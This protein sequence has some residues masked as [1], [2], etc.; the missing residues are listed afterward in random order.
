M[1]KIRSRKNNIATISED[2]HKEEVLN[3][4][5]KQNKTHKI[6]G[7]K[8]SLASSRTFPQSSLPGSYKL[9]SSEGY[10][11][12]L[13]AVGCGPLSLNM[14]MRSASFIEIQ[15]VIMSG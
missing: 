9:V 6:L 14:V 5:G 15:R 12:Y 7:R 2:L 8:F 10:E 11:E 1:Q 13:R 3:R 4:E